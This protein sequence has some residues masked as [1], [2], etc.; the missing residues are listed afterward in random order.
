MSQENIKL[1]L[2]K[3]KGKTKVK[4]TKDP[5]DKRVYFPNPTGKVS[6]NDFERRKYYEENN[7]DHLLTDSSSDSD[8]ENFGALPADFTQSRKTPGYNHENMNLEE[9][10][11]FEKQQ[12]RIN[13]EKVVTSWT[14]KREELV[15]IWIKEL[16]F[17]QVISYF[18]L[19]QVK[20][21]ENT[22]AW[23]IIVLSAIVSTI[24]LIQFDKDEDDETLVLVI[25][26]L[27]TVFTTFITLIAAWMKKQNYVSTI[28]E[29]EKYLQSLSIVL[30]ELNGQIK[31]AREDRVEFCK[32]LE[33]YKDKVINFSSSMPLISPYDWKHTV[34]LLTKYYPELV[35]D[36][37]PWNENKDFSKL[38]LMTYHNVKYRT[39]FRRLI[40]GYY[41]YSSCCKSEEEGVKNIREYFYKKKK[42]EESKYLDEID[43]QYNN[44]YNKKKKINKNDNFPINI[45]N[46]N[47]PV[48]I[49]MN[50][51]AI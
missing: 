12:Q 30:S 14:D 34:Y 3:T 8:N 41:C 16:E 9:I 24:S 44:L 11:E 2:G 46:D 15:N 49:K 37:Y 7:I 27:V 10:F 42:I 31:I 13:T 25:N 17:Y 43:E 28:S 4:K 47:E 32:F 22:W 18:Y 51:T 35:L 48:N 1:T 26:V 36:T 21:I 19:F 39:C 23:L 45:S 20:K 40:S 5:L 33:K 29:V 50:E 6:R 38:I